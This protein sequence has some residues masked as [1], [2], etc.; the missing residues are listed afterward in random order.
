MMSCN[1]LAANCQSSC[2]IPA[3]PGA[4]PAGTGTLN[5]TP[6]TTCSLGC[7][8]NQ[9]ACQTGCARLSPSQ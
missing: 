1:A 5:A 2:V 8:S 6:S 9:L 7:S 4:T 3:P